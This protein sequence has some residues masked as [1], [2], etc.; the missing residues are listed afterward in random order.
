MMKTKQFVVAVLLVMT[1]FA[2]G[3]SRSHV[4]RIGMVI[5]IKPEKIAEYKA[6]HADSNPGVR[7]LLTKYHIR[8]FSIYLCRLNDGKYYLF[9]LRIQRN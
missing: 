1:G 3:Y 4:H 5:G 7:D 6:L 8:N 2:A 9:V